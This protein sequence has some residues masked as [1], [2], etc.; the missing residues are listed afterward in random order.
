MFAKDYR[1]L[2]RKNLQSNWMLSVGVAT[3]A[4]LLG[5]LIVGHI[6]WP[7]IEPKVR[8]Y[9]ITDQDPIT[10]AVTHP[11]EVIR[12]FRLSWVLNLVSLILGGV[13]QLGYAQYL[14][15]QHDHKGPQFNDLFSKFDYFGAGFCQAFLRNLYVFLWSLLLIVPGIVAQYSYAMTPFIMAEHPELTASEAIRASKKMMNGNK[16]ALF[17]L[18]LSF[19]GWVL[20]CGL[21]L[22]IGNIFLNPYMNAAYAAFYRRI[23]VSDPYNEL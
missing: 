5:G 6:F 2:A 3:I 4:C 22:N 20:L 18:Q 12:N 23:S 19:F 9:I 10:Y 8:H 1:R 14:L 15:N 21:T 11:S 17:C 16:W 7:V 13:T